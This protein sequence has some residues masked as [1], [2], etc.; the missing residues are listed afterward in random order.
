M[1]GLAGGFARPL[2]VVVAA[3]LGVQWLLEQ[4]PGGVASQIL[5]PAASPEN[6]AALEAELGLDEPFLARYA[7]WLADALRGDLGRS[8]IDNRSVLD[9][10][11]SALPVTLELVVLAS[12][13]ALALALA[14][15]LLSA[16]RPHGAID[17]FSSLVAS[18]ALAVPTFVLAP[19]LVYVFAVRW[20]WFPVT[21][22]VPLTESIGGNLR[23]AILPALAIALPEFAVFQRVLRGDL[24]AEMEAD[25]IDGARARG[26]SES[27]VI[28]HHALKPASISLVTITGLSVGRLL[29]G[30]ILVEFLFVLPGLGLL[31]Q[32]SIARRDLVVVQGIVVVVAVSYVVLNVL[33]DRLYGRI[34]PRVRTRANR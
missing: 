12:T 32:Q 34:D 27:R 10:I 1:A 2:L 14:T 4:A 13:M 22:W 26:V 25:H 31:L 29:G 17:R 3:T 16:R 7:G 30:T 9:A 5:G 6:V 20:S 24:V 23:H 28:L 18:G 21:G 15:A 33:V 19:V 11:G 8:P